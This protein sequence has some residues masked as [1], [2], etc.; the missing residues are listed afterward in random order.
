MKGTMDGSP[1]WWLCMIVLV[2]NNSGLCFAQ[3]NEPTSAEPKATAQ[4]EP[5]GSQPKPPKP[6]LELYGFAMMD[7]GY[8]FKQ[9]DPDWFDVVRPVKLPSKANEF[10]AD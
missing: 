4:S 2:C 7:A 1:R 10:G 5:A 9:V 6:K 8:D 3:S